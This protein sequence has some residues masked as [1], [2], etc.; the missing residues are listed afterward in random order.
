MRT[1]V[2]TFAVLLFTLAGCDKSPAATPEQVRAKAQECA[3]A[4]LS[5]D[6]G[7]VADLSHPKVVQEIGGKQ[8]MI[9][10][11][12]TGVA[13]MKA[14]QFAL[15]SYKAQAPPEILG[16]GSDRM[17]VL[18]TAMEMTTPTGKLKQKSYLLG[19][20]SDGGRNWTFV[21]GSE[22]TAEKLKFVVPNPPNDLK[23]PARQTPVME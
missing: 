19:I 13:Q 17:A 6:Y 20:S 4:M 16:S 10:T 5:G 7:K 9:D 22:M 2:F 15:V 18:P 23:L 11:L 14:Q 1:P 12:K 8:K 21:D 3:D